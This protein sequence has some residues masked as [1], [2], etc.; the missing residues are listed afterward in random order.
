MIVKTEAIV[1]NIRPYSRTSH[2]VT[3]LTRDYGRITTVVKGACRAKSA[4]LGQYDLFYTCELLFYQRSR[5][6]IYI[7]RECSPLEFREPLRTDWRGAAAAGYIAELTSHVAAGFT[8]RTYSDFSHAL[9]ILCHC[10]RKSIKP[11][12][13]WYEMRILRNHG[14]A[15]D[16]TPCPDCS[17]SE[18]EWIRFSIPAGRIICVHSD[19]S[20]ERSPCV[21]LHREV[22]KVLRRFARCET[23]EARQ[24]TPVLHPHEKTD[25]KS[26]LIL[27]LSRFLG[28]FIVFHLDMPASVRCTV[29]EILNSKPALI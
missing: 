21:T 11:L 16:F 13:F 9:D 28:I 20:N 24:Y 22:V 3:W 1:L 4:F 6:G 17:F 8:D 25:K 10:E 26:N 23:F 14:T 29:F 12:L 2:V 15:P 27:G 19:N 5:N 7:I 18:S